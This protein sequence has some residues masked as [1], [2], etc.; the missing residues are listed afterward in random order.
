MKLGIKPK[1]LFDDI[2]SYSNLILHTAHVN[3]ELEWKIK[4]RKGD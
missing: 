4:G 1:R 2:I 3:K